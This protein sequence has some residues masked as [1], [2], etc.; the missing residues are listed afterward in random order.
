MA[1]DIDRLPATTLP[2]GYEFVEVGDHD[3]P[4]WAAFA[5]GY[6][7]PPGVAACFSPGPANAS[8]ALRFYAIRRGGRIVCTSA[9]HLSDGLAGVYCVSTIPGE[10]RRGLGAH[11][12]AEALRLA[13]RDGYRVGV[14]QSSEAGHGV[15][16]RLGFDEFGGVPLYVRIPG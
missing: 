12:T 2:D 7:L 4:E 8:P 14:L 3:A 10:R 13:A 1:V 16:R 15:Y 11:A 9:C 6:E 5:T